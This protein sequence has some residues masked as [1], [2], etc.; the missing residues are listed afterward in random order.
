MAKE[1][2]CEVLRVAMALERR[3]QPELR[4][5]VAELLEA[6]AAHAA[7][8]VRS[9][10]FAF[11]KE[12]AASATLAA[13][14]QAMRLA[15]ALPPPRTVA[16]A[17]A[18][19]DAFAQ[20][21]PST[22]AAR[23][24]GTLR[25]ATAPDAAAA[26]SV[27]PAPASVSE[28][29]QQR[30]P[31]PPGRASTAEWGRTPPAQPGGAHAVTQQR[32][33]DPWGQLAATPRASP[34]SRSQPSHNPLQELVAAVAGARGSAAG[35][36]DA[37]GPQRS[38]SATSRPPSSAS[39][40]LESSLSGR[41]TAP[42]TAPA[43]PAAPPSH[44][45]SPVPPGALWPPDEPRSPL[46][47][48]ALRTSS[49]ASNNP[50]DDPHLIAAQMLAAYGAE[51][52]AR[53]LTRIKTGP[54]RAPASQPSSARSTVSGAV[55]DSYGAN[56][57]SAPLP[58][59][60]PAPPLGAD[61]A[62][63]AS[64]SLDGSFAAS[65]TATPRHGASP[66][67]SSSTI[68]NPFDPSYEPPLTVRVGLRVGRD[69]S[70]AGWETLGVRRGWQRREDAEW[71]VVR[72]RAPRGTERAVRRR[73]ASRWRGRRRWTPSRRPTGIRRGC[74]ALSLSR[75]APSPCSAA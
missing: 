8:D 35:S 51:G 12:L 17:Y 2:A 75:A 52:G 62:A 43:T 47:F 27:A 70:G 13:I 49:S 24:I 53:Q 36:L 40:L 39:S 66:R 69:G 23:T 19:L 74:C 55:H 45:S 28:P 9:A 61:S 14:A 65:L 68:N 15:A 4:P 38:A 32:E 20:A 25:G 29:G 57:H 64:L 30:Q 41:V 6:H 72:R 60:P 67:A 26:V 1:D 37:G 11:L 44:P 31:P 7:D 5:L 48:Q 58:P 59:L 54:M 18:I 50:F 73:A 56:A 21:P 42:S 63:F 33:V 46:P 34:A 16:H 10:C 3:S 71:R 22:P